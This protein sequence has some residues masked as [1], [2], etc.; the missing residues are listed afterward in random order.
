MK[1][2][3]IAVILAVAI[4]PVATNANEVPWKGP[5]W[6]IESMFSPLEEGP[7]PNQTLCE[8]FIRAHMDTPA[9]FNCSYMTEDPR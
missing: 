3:T 4:T 8:D 6:Y 7:F 9:L 5:G 2:S 1:R